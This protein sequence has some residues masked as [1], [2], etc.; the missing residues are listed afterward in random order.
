[1]LRQL[2]LMMTAQQLAE[3]FGQAPGLDQQR[4]NF[5]V[6]E[7][8]QF[9]LRLVAQLVFFF[10][11]PGDR[12]GQRGILLIYNENPQIVQNSREKQY[13]R[14]KAA[15]RSR[16]Q[17][18]INATAQA[19][20]PEFI[21]IDALAVH[22]IHRTDDRGNQ[23]QVAQI[24][25]TDDANRGGNGLDFAWQTVIGTVGDTQ[26]AGA[27]RGIVGNDFGHLLTRVQRVVDNPLQ[28]QVYLR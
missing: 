19:M 10:D 27:Q 24:Q 12:A 20:Q 6:I 4:R 25:F 9:A 5:G 14:I 7:S 26:Q 8:Q 28:P 15:D 23:H 3:I 1:M 11:L 17:A 21:D 13:F 16:N 2:V 18:R 22:C